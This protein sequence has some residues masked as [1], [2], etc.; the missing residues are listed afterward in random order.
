M[1][2]YRSV[3][4]NF[5]V[6]SKWLKIVN[7]LASLEGRSNSALMRE[8]LNLGLAQYTNMHYR[9]PQL[10]REQQLNALLNNQLKTAVSDAKAKASCKKD[11]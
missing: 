3:Q 9:T 8:L 5:R 4:V 2:R 6:S 7:M 11:V 1:K 10:I